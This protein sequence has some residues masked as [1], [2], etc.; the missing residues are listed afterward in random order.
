MIVVREVRSKGQIRL[1]RN[2]DRLTD[3]PRRLGRD[4]PEDSHRHSG[5]TALTQDLWSR[6]SSPTHL[7]FSYSSLCTLVTL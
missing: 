4:P 2:Q 1:L 7:V 6:L 5:P 3:P